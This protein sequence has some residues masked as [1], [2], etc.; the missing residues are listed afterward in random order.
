MT[1]TN[2]AFFENKLLFLKKVS[3]N[4]VEKFIVRR[5][6]CP[7]LLNTWIMPPSP[8]D[9]INGKEPVNEVKISKC[10]VNI[11]AKFTPMNQHADELIFF[12]DFFDKFWK[13]KTPR[14]CKKYCSNWK[15]SFTD[16]KLRISAFHRHW[17]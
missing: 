14:E 7:V 3:A 5:V 17:S 1:K 12:Y 4:F 6:H 13:F 8:I 2:N 15:N 10:S 9:T 16:V 11:H